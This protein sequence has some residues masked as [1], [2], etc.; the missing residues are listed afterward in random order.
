MVAMVTP[1][2]TSVHPYIINPSFSISLAIISPTV[3]HSIPCC[4]F[5]PVSVHVINDAASTASRATVIAVDF[6]HVV[7][8]ARP[9]VPSANDSHGP[10]NRWWTEYS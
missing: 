1:H 10:A 4:S 2:P 6:G 7:A 3:V 9:A 5:H 8:M